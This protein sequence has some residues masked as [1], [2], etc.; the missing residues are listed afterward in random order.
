LIDLTRRYRFPAAHVLAHPRLSAAEN[1]RIYGKCANPGG[2]GHD[3]GLEV[4]VRGAVDPRSGQVA[5]RGAFDAVVDERVLE[6]FSHRMLNDDDAFGERVPTAENIAAVIHAELAA[7]LAER[8]GV[9]LVRVRLH[10]TR[11]NSFVYGEVT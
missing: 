8:C 11:K 9:R 4:T 3:Y 10:E 6:R 7:P 2:H 1:V 5:D